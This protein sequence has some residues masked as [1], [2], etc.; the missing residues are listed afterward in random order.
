LL[1]HRR[2]FNARKTSQEAFSYRI[3]C[4]DFYFPM[5]L[6][7]TSRQLVCTQF[8]S[9]KKLW[10]SFR[11]ITWSSFSRSFRSV[12]RNLFIHVSLREHAAV[13]ANISSSRFIIF[14]KKNIIYKKR[15]FYM[16]FSEKCNNLIQYKK[17][18]YK[19]TWAKI[20]ANSFFLSCLLIT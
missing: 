18:Q 15:S 14:R 7:V 20:K 6:S 9:A 1:S 3:L 5:V 13:K 4:R 19:K 10:T 2:Y 12:A 11:S 17:R 8:R 16:F